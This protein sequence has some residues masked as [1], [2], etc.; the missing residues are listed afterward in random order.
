MRVSKRASQAKNERSVKP[1]HFAD[2][3]GVG[4]RLVRAEYGENGANDVA[5]K[6]KNDAIV[7]RKKMIHKVELFSGEE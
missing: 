1:V 5:K 2:E 6:K 3:K 4:G 7:R